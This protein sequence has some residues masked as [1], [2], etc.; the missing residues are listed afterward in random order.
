MFAKYTFSDIRYN[1][2]NEFLAHKLPTL[3]LYN[4]NS[5]QYRIRAENH[6][7]RQ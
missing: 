3:M 6:Y 5:P 2:I 4:Y 7:V 1:A